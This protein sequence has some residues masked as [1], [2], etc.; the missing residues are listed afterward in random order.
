MIDAEQ[1]I[2]LAKSIS[3]K[4]QK[5]FPE[6]PNSDIEEAAM[7]GL[8][9]AA[10]GF[11]PSFGNKFSSFAYPVIS[12]EIVDALREHQRHSKR[13]SPLISIDYNRT[14]D[15][16]TRETENEAIYDLQIET[17]HKAILLSQFSETQKKVFG[18]FLQGLEPFEIAKE[19]SVTDE[20]VSQIL[21]DKIIPTLKKW[22]QR[23]QNGRKNR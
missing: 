18:F 19:R 2:G 21:N 1:H 17:L 15:Y 8:A 13:R 23:L 20:A 3:I 4:F 5:K 12:N 6:V 10:M 16:Y 7:V 14:P 22:F 11:Q 9:K